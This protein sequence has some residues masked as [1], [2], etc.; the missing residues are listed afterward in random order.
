MILRIAFTILV[1]VHGLIHLMG[2]AKAFELA[3]LEELSLPISKPWGILW[4]VAFVLFSVAGLFY[5]LRDS[6]WWLLGL[7]AV[8]LSQIII[9]YF[10]QD[11]KFGTIAN[12]IILV[13]TIIGY[14]NWAFERSFQKDVAQ[15]LLSNT[16][17]K[18][19]LITIED[20]AHLPENVKQYLH[21]VGIVGKPKVK[22][23]QITFEGEMRSKGEEWFSFTSQQ[24]NFFDKPSRF[25]FIKAKVKGIHT[26]GYH[27]YQQGIAN[28]QIKL[29]S[30]FSV[31]NEQGSVLDKTETVTYFNDLC[32]FAPAVLIDKR[33]QWKAVSDTRAVAQLSVGEHQVSATL[34]FNNEHQLISFH[35]DDRTDVA[36]GN[37]YRFSTPVSKYQNFNG[38]N[39]CS[40]GEAVWHYPSGPF[41]YGK[42][43]VKQITY[44]VAS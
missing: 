40:Y 30:L 20:L 29:L 26:T 2:F 33:I 1:A 11:A 25:F 15:G 19:E 27:A 22:N 4:G 34:D 8:V 44:N 37:N 41:V 23:V 24:Y 21:Y 35:S 3:S 42:F 39:I 31:V 6:H 14:G 28:M 38:Y 17:S 43:R 36:D 12:S 13:A 10:W 16:I 9:F 32:L 5:L 18:H 7:V